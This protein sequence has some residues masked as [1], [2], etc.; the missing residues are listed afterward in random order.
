MIFAQLNACYA[1]PERETFKLLM[2]TSALA[3]RKCNIGGVKEILLQEAK[4]WRDRMLNSIIR[5]ATPI[6]GKETA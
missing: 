5:S 6:P 2:R 3:W 1:R 4:Y